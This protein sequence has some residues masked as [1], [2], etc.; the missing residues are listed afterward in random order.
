MKIFTGSGDKDVDNFGWHFILFTTGHLLISIV[1]L[2][3]HVSSKCTIFQAFKTHV[4]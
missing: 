4:D 2:S 1:S 3:G